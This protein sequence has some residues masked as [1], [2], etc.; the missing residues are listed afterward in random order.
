[1][2][3]FHIPSNTSENIYGCNCNLCSRDGFRVRTGFAAGSLWNKEDLG[4]CQ[5]ALDGI[6]YLSG[7][8]LCFGGC[9]AIGRQPVKSDSKSHAGKHTFFSGLL[10]F[11]LALG[12]AGYGVYHANRMQYKSYDIQLEE[13]APASGLTIVLISDLHLGAVGSEKRIEDMVWGINKLEPDLVCIAGD[14]FDNDYYVIHN[15]DMVSD[16]LKKIRARYGVYACL[17]NHDG[18]ETLDEMLSFLE[19][20]NIKLLADE[21]ITI[22]ERLILVGRLDPSP[23]GG[24]GDMERKELAEVM[25]GADVSLPV[26][27]MDHDPGNIDEYG[28]EI[29]LILSGHTHRGQIFPGNLFTR[30]MYGERAYGYSRKDD[31]STHVVVTSGAGTWGMP[32]RVGTDCEI[33]SIKLH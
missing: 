24:F 10:V 22:D 2:C 7:I 13:N 21:Y 20:S 5:Y 30:L 23:I 27:V 15:A 19:R 1:M 11:L 25:A 3:P 17:G 12:T 33:V 31:D 28:N 32:M 26:V 18:G 4:N 8:V 9:S 29:N 6:F 14:M 16:A